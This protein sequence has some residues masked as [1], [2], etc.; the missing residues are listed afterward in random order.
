M[1]KH[2]R[3][4]YIHHRLKNKYYFIYEFLNIRQRTFNIPDKNYQQNIFIFK[5]NPYVEELLKKF[6]YT[7]QKTII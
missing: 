5:K 3:R 2:S 1:I 6:N 4:Y 7:I